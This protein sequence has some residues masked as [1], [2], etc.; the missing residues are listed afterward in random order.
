[1]LVRQTHNTFIRTNNAFGY[2]CNQATRLD[3]MY[4]ETGADYL[5]VIRRE[6]QDVEW[7]VKTK[8]LPIYDGVEYDVL[9]QDFLNFIIDLSKFGFLVY[10][11]TIE[12]LDEAENSYGHIGSNSLPQRVLI[13]ESGAETSETTQLMGQQQSIITPYLMS[14]QFELTSRCNERCVHCYIPNS[15]KDQ[16]FDMPFSLFKDII[17]QFRDMGGL[18]VSLSGGE[19]FMHSHLVEMMQYCREKDL[20]VSLLSNLVFLRDDHIPAIKSANVAMV[21]TSLYSM[22]PEIHDK[23]TKVKGSFQKTKIAIEKLVDSGIPVTISCPI[24]NLNKDGY[25]DILAYAHSLGI[26]AQTDFILMAEE[27]LDTSNLVN[28]ISLSDAEVIIRQIL[29]NNRKDTD[30]YVMKSTAHDAQIVE[31]GN[32]PICAAGVNNLC[33]SSNG[34]V[35]PCNGWQAYKAGNIKEKTLKDIWDNSEVLNKLRS[36]RR[37]DFPK[38]AN[39]EAS[40]FCSIC[41]ARNHNESG[42]NP[43]K[44]NP[45]F[46]DI[47]FL[48]KKVYEETYGRLTSK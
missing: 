41:M 30:D 47:A 27:N 38:C 23:I 39:C 22:T 18:Q 11:D 25:K 10:G 8:L 46:C 35:Y 42:G 45:H 26:K 29:E 2:I 33:V 4:N 48:N 7:L 44:L 16:G 43:L 40:E 36:I 31:V 37:S 14:L 20:Q 17:D 34:D 28:R 9:F 3:R 21:Q 6:V 15:K 19:I 12:I 1:M 32:I 24:L 5:S 13:Q